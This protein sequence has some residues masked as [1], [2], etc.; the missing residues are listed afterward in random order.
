MLVD[1]RQVHAEIT[2][3]QAEGWLEQAGIIVNKNMIPFDERK[4]TETSGL[5]IRTPAVSTRGLGTA[6]M[7]AVA[8]MIHQVISAKGDEAVTAK[9]RKRV[10]EICEAFPMPH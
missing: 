7:V 1:L 9:V 8:E 10:L 3:K 2:G 5:R 4:P 6:E